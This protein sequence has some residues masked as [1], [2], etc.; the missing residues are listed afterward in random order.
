M[1]GIKAAE[2][3]LQQLPKVLP[4]GPGLICINARKVG[5][6]NELEKVALDGSVERRVL[7]ASATM[8]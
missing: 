4:Y 7:R 8:V 3:L 6:L 5:W 2:N 1:K